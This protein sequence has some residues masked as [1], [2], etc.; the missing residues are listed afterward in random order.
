MQ[1]STDSQS[2]V[3]YYFRDS[4]ISLDKDEDSYIVGRGMVIH[5][6]PENLTMSLAGGRLACCTIVESRSIRSVRLWN[7]WEDI[8]GDFLE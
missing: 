7:S 1:L 4:D 2:K 3:A 6:N 8:F 5:E